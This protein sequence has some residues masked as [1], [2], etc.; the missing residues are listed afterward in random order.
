MSWPHDRNPRSTRAASNANA[1]GVAQPEVRRPPERSARTGPPRLRSGTDSSQ[2]SSPVK[3]TRNAQARTPATSI[4]R[5]WRNGQAAA[6]TSASVSRAS[7]S[8]DRG[9]ARWSVANPEVTSVTTAPAGRPAPEQRLGPS[10]GQGRGEDEEPVLAETRDRRVHLD[11]AALVAQQRVDDP[12]RRPRRGRTSPA[13]GAR[14]APPGPGRRTSRRSRG[15]T[16]RRPRASRRT[17]SR[18]DGNHD[19]ATKS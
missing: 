12:A 10:L 18:T 19:G 2:P 16:A 11:P 4:S 6:D 7:S 9:P 14:R 15:R 1:P 5:A 17:S 8:R 3:E 13:A